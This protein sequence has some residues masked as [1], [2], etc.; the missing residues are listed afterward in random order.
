MITRFI[1]SVKTSFNP[2][3]PQSKTARLFLSFLP[4]DARQTMKIDAKLLPQSSKERSFIEL[5]FS[6]AP[7]SL[8]QYTPLWLCY[9]GNWN[10]S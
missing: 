7:C 4:P 2:F 3:R 8:A 6:K 1:T 5:K 9:T 10:F